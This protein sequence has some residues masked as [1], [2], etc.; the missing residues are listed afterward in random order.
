MDGEITSRPVIDNTLQAVF[1]YYEPYYLSLGM[2]AEEYWNGE[3]DRIHAYEQAEIYR[4]KQRNVNAWVQ[5]S[6]IYEALCSA[7]SQAFGGEG[8][9]VEAP[10]D[11]YLTKQER[12]AKSAKEN[13][14]RTD[15]L[16]QFFDR[17]IERQKEL[18]NDRGSTSR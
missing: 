7:L 8:R 10:Y 16:L 12:E 9:Y 15:A 11:L 13:Q 4:Q 5:G 18:D 2:P 6:Y 17:E 1:S 14:A 3:P